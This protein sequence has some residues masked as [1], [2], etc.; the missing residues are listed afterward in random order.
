M[1]PIKKKLIVKPAVKSEKLVKAKEERIERAKSMVGREVVS[2]LATM[3]ALT[4][5]FDEKEKLAFNQLCD[6]ANRNHVFAKFSKV[7]L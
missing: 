5:F 2:N 6:D 7:N 1:A 3:T 4:E